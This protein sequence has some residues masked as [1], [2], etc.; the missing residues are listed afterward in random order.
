[1]QKDPQTQSADRKANQGMKYDVSRAKAIL[2]LIILTLLYMMA[3][4]DRSVMTVVVELMKADIGLTDGQIGFLQT[5]FMVGVG[6]MMIPCGVMVDRWSRRKAIGLMAII[7]SIATY[8][9][10]LVS[11]FGS[12]VGA[13]FLTSSGEAGFAPGSV[14][15]I[16]LTFP[17]ESRAKVLGIFNMGIPLGGALGVVL[18]G[19][20]AAKTGSWRTPFYVFAVPGIVLGLIAFFLPDYQTIK[21]KTDKPF[22]RKN[23]ADILGLFK[24]RSLILAAL[25]FSAWVFLVF[26]L[27]GWM[28]ALFMR[29]YT[30]DAAKAGSITGLIYVLGALGGVI[31]GIFSDRW[32]RRNKRGRFLFI[33]IFILGGTLTKLILFLS[34]GSALKLVVLIAVV[35]AFVS[36]LATPA[37]FAITQDVVA[38]KLRATSLA[39]S[40]NLI[41]L[42][43]G[44]WGP[45]VIGSFSEQLG[46]GAAGLTTSLLYMVPA[47]LLAALFFFIGLRFYASDCEGIIDEVLAEE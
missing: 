33:V 13:R 16:S 8:L 42:T 2:I 28:P 47:G 12:L 14:A 27:A 4:M 19:L 37:Y 30:L 15:W 6:L 46:G 21:S 7:W 29:Q 44:A 5:T 35:D 31:G 11:R 3:Y 1:M 39:L 24:I 34:F 36:N 26:G 43:G 40:A 23:L 38:P 17:K 41:F 45:T 25:G 9:T 20:I 22:D 10:G 32:Q 18:G